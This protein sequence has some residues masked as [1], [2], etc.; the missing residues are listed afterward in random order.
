MCKYCVERMDLQTK[1]KPLYAKER[2]WVGLQ[3]DD[4]GQH[5]LDIDL[6]ELDLDIPINFCPMCG[7]RLGGE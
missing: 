6:E 2:S 4:D 5:V 1:L 7:R 3:E